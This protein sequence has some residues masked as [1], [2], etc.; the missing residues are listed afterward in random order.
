MHGGNKQS[1]GAYVDANSRDV[2]RRT[3]TE[4]TLKLMETVISSRNKPKSTQAVLEL[5]EQDW[6]CL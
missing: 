3:P 2:I 6:M 5:Q 1:R 4:R